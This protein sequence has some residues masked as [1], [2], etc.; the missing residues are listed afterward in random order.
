MDSLIDYLDE[1]HFEREDFVI[2]PGQYAVRGG[3]IDV[4]SYANDYPYR[5]EFFGDNIAS[6]RSFNPEDQLSVD[7]LS[8]VNIIPDLNDRRI[9]HKRENLQS[10]LPDD[11]VI[12]VEDV[13]FCRDKISEEHT[14]ALKTESTYEEGEA[15]VELDEM[16]QQGEEWL[17]GLED[18]RHVEFSRRPWKE[19][20]IMIELEIAPQ[21]SFNKNFDLLAADLQKH[22]KEGFQ[23]LILSGNHKQLERLYS[24]FEDRESSIQ[25]PASSLVFDTMKHLAS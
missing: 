23:N 1:Q 6:L 2:A 15:V 3:I 5:I 18:F 22:S 14:K 17:S 11:A 10:L 16:F 24:I 13:H 7:T 12:W 20:I 21:P 9:A 25:N 8:R 4:F 19:G